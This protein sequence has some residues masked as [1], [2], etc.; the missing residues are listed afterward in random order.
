ML[1]KFVFI[2]TL[3]VLGNPEMACI[4][5]HREGHQVVGHSNC[6]KVAYAQSSQSHPYNSVWALADSWGRLVRGWRVQCDLL[7]A[8]RVLGSKYRILTAGPE[9]VD[10]WLL[11]LP[12]DQ[13]FV[14]ALLVEGPARMYAR[15]LQ[16]ISGLPNPAALHDPFRYSK[17][18]QIETMGP[19]MN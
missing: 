13:G 4:S 18:H 5:R 17:D 10:K 11:P 9:S 16:W 15:F 3:E 2:F 14:G 1:G 8:S 12:A 6:S 19:L 7:S